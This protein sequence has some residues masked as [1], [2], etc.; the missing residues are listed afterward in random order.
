MI[1]HDESWVW[2]G[3]R[4]PFDAELVDLH[5][6]QSR[7]YDAWVEAGMSLR[8]ALDRKRDALVSGE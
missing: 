7:A 4:I 5:E 3:V 8:A 2:K 6:I 1:P